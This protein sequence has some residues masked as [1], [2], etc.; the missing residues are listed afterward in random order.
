MVPICS[1]L[2]MHSFSWVIFSNFTFTK[3]CACDYSLLWNMNL[4][5]SHPPSL[6]RYSSVLISDSDWF[7]IFSPGQPWKLHTEVREVALSFD[8][9]MIWGRRHTPYSINLEIPWT[10]GARNNFSLCWFL[11]YLCLVFSAC[12]ALS[13]TK[14]TIYKI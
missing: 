6:L 10:T 12:P 7:G 8:F 2:K 9:Q 13:N 4:H 1:P 5:P 14:N 11:T 3:I